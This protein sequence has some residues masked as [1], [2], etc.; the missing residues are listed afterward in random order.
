MRIALGIEYDGS[1]FAGWQWQPEKR[2]VQSELETALSYVA[3]NPVRLVCAGRT[4]AGVHATAQIAHF[5]TVVYRKPFSWMMG[6]N[7]RLPSDIRVTWLRVVDEGFHARSSAIAR[8]YRYIILNRSTRSALQR[9]Q[10]TWNPVPMD[11]GRMQCAANYLVGEHDFSSFRAQGC[12]SRSPNRRMYF[13]SVTRND[14][15]VTIDV[16]ANAFL[17]HMVRNIAGALMDVGTGKKSP[18]W[19][20]SL[21]DAK[22]RTIGSATAPPHGLYFAGTHYP[23]C[24]GLPGYPIFDDLPVDAQRINR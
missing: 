8:H 17:H 4:D 2:T 9:L 24:F 7:S 19:L 18:E 10:V 15:L 20:C 22:D 23:A 6:S 16:C 14:C 12:Q 13:I 3:D 11:V 21:L 1:G 5:D